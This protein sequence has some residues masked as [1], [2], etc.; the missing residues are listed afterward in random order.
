MT[1]RKLTPEEERVILHKGTE[2]PFTGEYTDNK[3]SGTYHCKQ[4][5]ARLYRSKDKFDSHCGWPSFDDEIE[6][7]I[8]ALIAELLDL[9]L[10]EI[11][12]GNYP[13]YTSPF[14]L[15]GVNLLRCP[16]C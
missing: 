15:P 10:I 14:G 13:R 7:D 4:C 2:R 16:V 5:D 3:A 1:F 9:D 8:Y 12:N 11:K 6:G